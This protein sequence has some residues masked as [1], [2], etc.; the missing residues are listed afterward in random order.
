MRKYL[1]LPRSVLL[2]V[3]LFTNRFSNDASPEVLMK[4]KRVAIYARVSTRDKQET[5]NQLAQLREFC[6]RQGWQVVTP[7]YIDHETGSTPARD[8][9]QKMLLDAS[10][11]KFSVLLFW[12]LDRLTREGTLATLQYLERL[13]SY[14]VGY[15][16]LT[17]P[18]L[19]SCG[20][21][22]DVVISVL[23]TMA[24]QERLRMGERVRA[25]LQH[26]RSQGKRLGRPPLRVLKPKD[27]AEL[28]KE[29]AQTKMPF[30]EL[31]VKHRIS[32]FTAHQLC[33]R[34]G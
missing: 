3:A 22:K 33:A 21:F 20:T 24:K 32:V 8:E 7:E 19:D 17:E 25:G 4:S 14:E 6:R 16:S 12:S 11:R 23:A 28:R 31:A 2:Q 15:R 27:V 29:R 30:R 10:Q 1:G 26:A 5:L 9:F 34:K 18:Y 13:T